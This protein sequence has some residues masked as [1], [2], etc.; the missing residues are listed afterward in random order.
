M[1][2]SFSCLCSYFCLCLV[3]CH[4]C[5]GPEKNIKFLCYIE[6]SELYFYAGGGDS[7]GTILGQVLVSFV[8]IKVKLTFWILVDKKVIGSF[9]P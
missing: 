6:A 1:N 4:N 3:C 7:A 8:K 2:L 5:L 9:S